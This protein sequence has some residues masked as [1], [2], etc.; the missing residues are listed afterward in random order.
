MVAKLVQIGTRL[1]VKHHLSL[2]VEKVTVSHGKALGVSLDS[3]T[4]VEADAIVINADL[5]YAFKSLL[6]SVPST[7]NVLSRSKNVSCSSISFYW[8]L[9]KTFPQLETHN[10]FVESSFRQRSTQ[11][12]M[13]RQSPMKTSFYVHVPSRVDPTAAPAGKDAVIVL[14]LVENLGDADPDCEG[15]DEANLVTFAREH[16]I[17]SIEKRTGTTGFHKLIDHESVNTPS[18]WQ[19]SFNSEKG[20]LFGL[21]HN[22]F[23]ILSF[24]PKIKHDS[25]AG[26][27][28]VGASTHPGAGVPTCLAGARLT[29]ERV[30]QDLEVA[31][32][33]DTS[34]T[35]KSHACSRSL[36]SG[37][38]TQSLWKW[39]LFSISIF[40]VIG[41]SLAGHL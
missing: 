20:G 22:L 23:N 6:P 10:M 7:S 19:E 25:V 5:I 24:R 4:F 14:V 16:V 18:T 17:S 31:I 1:G 26:V 32:P 3:S 13:K 15:F 9:S 38:F 37:L 30:L 35:Q 12:Y 33:W 34:N 21:D 8:S 41:L 11:I 28:F 29:A 27:Y 39:T 36:T 40:M 2:P